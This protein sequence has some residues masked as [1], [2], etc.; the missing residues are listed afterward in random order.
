MISKKLLVRQKQVFLSNYLARDCTRKA[1]Q[2]IRKEILRNQN[3]VFFSFQDYSETKDKVDVISPQI[4]QNKICRL[5]K[6]KV[7]AI[8]LKSSS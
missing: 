6:I 2:K 4:K 1:S 3:N 8:K 7:D 5:N